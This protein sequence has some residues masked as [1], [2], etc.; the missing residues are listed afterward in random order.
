MAEVYKVLGQ[1]KPI[2]ITLTDL[3]TVPGATQ[4]STSS[5]IICNQG[6]STT[7]RVSIA[8][9]AAVDALQQYIV[10]DI[11]LDDNEMKTLTM[12]ITLA[13]TDKIRCYSASGGVSFSVYGVEIS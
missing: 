2:A 1:S 10:Y 5:I 8:I 13:A 12:G 3:Y 11:I 6:A 4:A 9:A 7:V